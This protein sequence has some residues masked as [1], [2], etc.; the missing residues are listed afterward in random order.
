ME[1]FSVRG[2][3]ALGPGD[4]DKLGFREVAKRIAMSLVDRASEDGLVVGLEG[5]WGSGKSSLLFLVGD[6]LTRLPT[7]ARPTVINFRPW[8]IGNRDALITSLFSELSN[9]LDQ[10]ALAAGD[11]TPISIAKAKKAGKALRSFMSALSKAGGMVEVAGDVAGIGAVKFAGKGLKAAGELAGTQAPPQLSDLKDRLVASLREL[12]HRFVVTIDD[13]DRLEPGEIL[14]ILRLVRSV[15]DLPNVIY[16]LCYD[17]EVLAHSIQAAASVQN[18]RAFLEK[19]IQL[20]VMVP[21]PEAF[22]LRQWFAEALQQIGTAKNEDERERLRQVIDQEGGRQLRT[23]RSVVR[24]LDSIRFFWP[25]LREIDADLADLVWLQ[26]IKDG[27]SALYRWIEEYCGT[28]AALSLG[29]ARVDEA[30]KSQ[31]LAALEA[32]AG[33]RVFD[34]HLYRHS[35]SAQLAGVTPNFSK[36]G[37]AFQLFER[38]DDRTRDEAIQSRRLASPDHYRLYF[39][40]ATPSH[41]LTQSDFNVLWEALAT[42]PDQTATVLLAFQRQNAAGTLT[43]ADLMIERIKGGAYELLDGKQC[44]NLLMALANS[45]DEA[46]RLRP[47]DGFAFSSQWDRALPLVGLLLGRL[48]P[49]QR[50]IATRDMF[51]EG[52]AIGWLTFVFRHEI[53]AHGRFGDRRRHDSDWVL[54]T[55]QQLDDA[56]RIMLSRYKAMALKDIQQSPRP[57]SLLFAWQ[58]AGDE[59]GPRQLLGTH[60]K[61]DEGLLQTLEGLTSQ[62]N[63]SN[64]GIVTVLSRENIGPFLDYEEAVKRVKALAKKPKFKGAATKIMK[65]IDEGKQF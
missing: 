3:R 12:G 56:I 35:F 60:G 61:S 16:L 33:E 9:Q 21:K 13:V 45:M 53:F 7:A 18:G 49:A 52:E 20:T 47:F 57:L 4:Q 50:N 29:T 62:I 34:D 15:V 28:A 8:L 51:A 26:L 37:P 24:A 44:R 65:L 5:A 63:T 17:S 36:S 2:D 48:K 58:Q 32:A 10:V 14:E 1:S 39:A 11:A 22:Q 23:P 42:S 46:F 31:Q 27:N 40:M 41:A 55:E 30:E 25:P 19:I 54:A 43:K 59:K 38:V 64:R 6:E